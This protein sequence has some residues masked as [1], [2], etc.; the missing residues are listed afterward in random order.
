MTA[1][2]IRHLA[3]AQAARARGDSRAAA[4]HASLADSAGAAIDFYRTRGDLDEQLH[5]A[6]QE[7]AARTAPMRLAAIQ[8]D[9][10]L[11][12]RHP[13]MPLEPLRSAESEALPDELP[14]PSPDANAR[15]ATLVADKLAV[16]HAELESRTGLLIPSEDPDYEPDGEACP[17]LSRP[18]RDAILQPP[19]PLMPAPH[20]QRQREPELQ[21]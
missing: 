14:E 20:L 7:W 8:A 15:H 18:R 16:F 17:D 4:R 19:R 10:L 11:R 5:A 2:Q 13:H 9:A 12:R 1:R 6:R 3:E 21:M